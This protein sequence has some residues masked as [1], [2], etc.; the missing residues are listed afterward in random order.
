MN[1]AVEFVTKFDLLHLNQMKNIYLLV[2]KVMDWILV[3]SGNCVDTSE[4]G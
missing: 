2:I 1:K 4:E 3:L